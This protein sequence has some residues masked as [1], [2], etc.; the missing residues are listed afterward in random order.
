MKTINESEI[1]KLQKLNNMPKGVTCYL[2]NMPAP[3]IPLASVYSVLEKGSEISCNIEN[4]C[5]I[6]FI[7]KGKIHITTPEYEKILSS[8]DIAFISSTNNKGDK[9]IYK[10]LEDSIAISVEHHPQMNITDQ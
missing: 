8:G 9:V 5:E 6:V 1:N 10:A 3:E 2:A 4:N 7:R